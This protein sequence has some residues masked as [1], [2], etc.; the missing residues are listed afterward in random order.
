M[1]IVFPKHQ[2][3]KFLTL[4]P[5]LFILLGLVPRQAVVA[6]IATVLSSDDTLPRRAE[7]AS[8]FRIETL[9]VGQ[10]A[11]LLTVFGS[12]DGLSTSTEKTKEVP[13]VSILR[14]TLGDRNPENDRLR[15]VWMLT[16]T[17]PSALQRVASAIPFLYGRV[18]DKKKASA[19]GMP[20]PVLDLADPQRDVW[21]RFMWLALQNVV[22]NP[23]GVVAKAST[24]ALRRNSERYRQAHILR[25]LAILSLYEAETGK[26]SPFTAAESAE[27][28]ARLMLTSKTFGGLIDDSYLDEVLRRQTTEMLDSRGHNWELLRQRAETEGLYF[29]PLEMPDGSATHALVWVAREDL[30]KNSK[31]K[32]GERFLNIANPWNDSR[33][34]RWDGFTET[35]YLDAAGRP[36]AEG[37]EGARK[38]ELIPLALYGLD[39][40]KIPTLLVDFRDHMNPKKREMSHRVIED[41]ARNVLSLSRYGDIHYFLGRTVFDFVTSRRGIDINQPTRL[42]AYSQLKLLLSLDATLDRNLRDEIGKR[43]ESVSLNP[44][45]NDLDAEARLAR[46][47]YAALVASARR[48]D[49]L[50]ARLDRERR[51]EMVPLEHGKAGRVIFRFANV[52][53]FG[54]YRHRESAPPE[55]VRQTLDGE[56]RLAYHKRFLEEVAKSTPLVE[57]VWNMED[58]RR[59]LRFV[60]EAGERADGEAARAAAKIFAQTQDGETRRLC[61]DCLYRIN[62]EAAK[63]ALLRIYQSPELDPDLR[64]LTAEYLRNALREDQRIAPED[65]R[66]IIATVGQ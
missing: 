42:R 2:A 32:F 44:L 12:L 61:L 53:S 52:L 14:D 65:A 51:E 50:P 21:Q 34:A 5:A 60:V 4:L 31:R 41:V 13:L 58:V 57:V 16:Y 7:G 8:P 63:S 6:Q 36:V 33:L 30:Q 28:Q 27:I 18:G 19:K 37:T 25:A 20:P 46:Q 39:F 40:P 64:R 47:Q 23:Y 62:N 45:E 35:R 54:A 1:K 15:Y 66:A 3:R 11:E 17:R 26:E 10:D 43:L 29:E 24:G 48:P 38:V 49:G 55:T 9:P 56:R 59:S 22:F